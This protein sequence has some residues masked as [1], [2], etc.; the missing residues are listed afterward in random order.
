MPMAG[1][2]MLGYCETGSFR[3]ESA[4]AIIST[5]AITQANT[6]LSIKT[7]PCVAP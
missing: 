2:A 1:G 6:G 4:P 3:M 7:L 5:I